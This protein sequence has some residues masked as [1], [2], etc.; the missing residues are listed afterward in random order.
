MMQYDTQYLC[1]HI[2]II[3]EYTSIIN[4]ENMVKTW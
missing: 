4:H 2:K 3:I 1:K